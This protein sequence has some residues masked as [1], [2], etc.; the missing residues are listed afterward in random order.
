LEYIQSAHTFNALA[1]AGVLCTEGDLGFLRDAVSEVA[2]ARRLLSWSYVHKHYEYVEDGTR[3]DDGVIEAS[4]AAEEGKDWKELLLEARRDRRQ[5]EMALFENAQGMLERYCEELIALI[6]APE[7]RGDGFDD[8]GGGRGL[9]FGQ[10][11]PTA[12]K[13]GDGFPAGL[14]TFFSAAMR[15]GG[16]RNKK[17]AGGGG[18]SMSGVVGTADEERLKQWGE[19]K[20]AVVGRHK[21][22]QQFSRNLARD[23]SQG[24]SDLR[25]TIDE[26]WLTRQRAEMDAV[27]KWLKIEGLNEYGDPEGTTYGEGGSSGGSG[28]A[29][30]SSDFSSMLSSPRGRT[31]A[32]TVKAG[33]PLTRAELALR[34][35]EVGD[36]SSPQLPDWVPRFMHITWKW[37]RK[38]SDALAAA[39]Q[40]GSS[41]PTKKKGQ[42]MGASP[43]RQYIIMVEEEPNAE[44]VPQWAWRDDS[45][46]YS[47][48]ACTYS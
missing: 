4:G 38:S 32:S 11:K 13:E 21:A 41:T 22:I 2:N 39:A 16:S 15:R 46:V 9:Q 26:R 19:F 10:S 37:Q 33:C 25:R 14:E 45:G 30:D 23:I 28:G 20:Q 7:A 5:N 36:E 42:E 18:S 3:D 6:Q 34:C 12:R 1:E 24:F 35:W 48:R 47:Y 43:W 31:G 17:G 29:S 44:E 8:G 40:G 27:E